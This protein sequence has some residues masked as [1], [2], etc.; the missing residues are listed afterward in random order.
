MSE[1]F[2]SHD[3]NEK[4]CTGTVLFSG[5]FLVSRKNLWIRGGISQ[6]SVEFFMS[7]SAENFRKAI[8][9]FLKIFGFKSFLDE[10]G[11]ITFFRRNFFGLI[12]PKNFVGMPSKF[13][14]NW[15]IE[16]FYA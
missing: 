3:R 14:K 13:H 7:H 8:L 15:G 11:G 4:L 1:F 5:N 6:I 10:K 12:V 2:V 16:K 9:L